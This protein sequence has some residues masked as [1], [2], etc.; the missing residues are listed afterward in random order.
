M[1]VGLWVRVC[2]L[3]VA[4]LTPQLAQDSLAAQMKGSKVSVHMAS[5]GEDARKD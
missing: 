3:R 5:P 2:A 4:K 1:V